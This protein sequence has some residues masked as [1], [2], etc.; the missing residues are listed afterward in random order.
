[1]LRIM[2]VS[3]Q[4]RK[5][6]GQ[7]SREGQDNQGQNIDLLHEALMASRSAEMQAWCGIGVVS[8]DET[9]QE[10]PT[11]RPQPCMLVELKDG[12]QVR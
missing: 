3:Q 11:R 9:E 8:N 7:C 5:E 4:E 6:Q 10:C 1:M 2:A 12:H